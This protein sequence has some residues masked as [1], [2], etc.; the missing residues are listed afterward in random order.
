M[1]ENKDISR[2]ERHC[3]S[4]FWKYHTEAIMKNGGDGSGAEEYALLKVLKAIDAKPKVKFV[5]TKG[6]PS[7]RINR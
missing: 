1:I 2:M 3:I 5:V 7:Q 6:K 4:L